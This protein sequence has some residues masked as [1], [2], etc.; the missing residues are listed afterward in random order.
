MT[1]PVSSSCVGCHER[2]CDVVRAALEMSVPALYGTVQDG[3]FRT[4]NPLALV[5]VVFRITKHLSIEKE[6]LMKLQEK[7]DGPE[8]QVVSPKDREKCFVVC[9]I[10]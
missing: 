7:C 4:F 5:Q 2:S 9:G 3:G 6:P 10:R 8:V 1:C